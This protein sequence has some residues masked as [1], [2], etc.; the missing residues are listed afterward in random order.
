MFDIT[1]LPP[2]L[3]SDSIVDDV[4]NPRTSYINL[5]QMNTRIINCHKNWNILPF[6]EAIKIKEKNLILNTSLKTSM[7]LQLF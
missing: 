1:K 6:K 2:S 7:E 3:L 5:V 4:Q